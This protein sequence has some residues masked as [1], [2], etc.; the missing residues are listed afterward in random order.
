M[1]VNGADKIHLLSDG[2]DLNTDG[3]AIFA[4]KRV[5]VKTCRIPHQRLQLCLVCRHFDIKAIY[6]IGTAQ[7][8]MIIMCHP[9][10]GS[11]D[12]GII[13]V[14]Q[15]L[16]KRQ[17]YITGSTEG[18]RPDLFCGRQL[19]HFLQLLQLKLGAVVVNGLQDILLGLLLR[20]E[21]CSTTGGHQHQQGTG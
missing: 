12:L 18:I 11:F 2:H 16:I 20:I 19:G 6:G 3:A 10:L 13:S 21:R 4:D 1:V 17:L 8:K 5:S 7:T 15:L 14:V 9:S